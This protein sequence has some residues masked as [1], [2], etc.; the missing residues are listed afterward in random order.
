ML[1]LRLSWQRALRHL[2]EAPGDVLERRREHVRNLER[3]AW[4]DRCIPRNGIGA[5]LGVHKGYFSPL[6]LSQLAPRKLYLIDPWFLQGKAW[7]WG[8]GNRNIVDALC[9]VMRD[10]EDD[11]IAGTLVLVIKDDLTALAEMPDGYLDW[12][13][14]DT[15]HRYEQ[16]VKELALLKIKVRAGGVIAG[17]D[18]HPDPSHKHYGVYRAVMEFVDQEHYRILEADPKSKQWAITSE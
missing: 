11:F 6:L 7:R 9:R 15:N 10:M 5:E 8:K 16:T 12:V 3:I 2:R 17:D 13:Y 4:L 1:R 18:W 14:L